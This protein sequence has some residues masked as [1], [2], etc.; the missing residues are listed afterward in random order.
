M[1]L[2]ILGSE[3]VTPVVMTSSYLLWHNVVSIHELTNSMEGL[4][5]KLTVAQLT[6]KC[7]FNR[8]KMFTT[9]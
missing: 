8:T 2:Y 3:V 1:N 4:S 9:M 6:K 7:P 5:E